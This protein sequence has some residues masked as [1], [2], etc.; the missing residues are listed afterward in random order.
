M[1]DSHP[2]PWQV[3]PVL[4]SEVEVRN[5]VGASFWSCNYLNIIWVILCYVIRVIIKFKSINDFDNHYLLLTFEE[6]GVF[7]WIPQGLSDL[8]RFLNVGA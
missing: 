3:L 5:P 1:L 4:L 6:P 7:F 2:P 8:L